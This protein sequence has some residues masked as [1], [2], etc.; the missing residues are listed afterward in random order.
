MYA[1]AYQSF[2][3]N[4]IISRRFKEFGLVPLAGDLVLDNASVEIVDSELIDNINDESNFESEEKEEDDEG[5]KDS[6]DQ[7]KGWFFVI[8]NLFYN[9]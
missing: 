5:D 3:W 7:R 9:V 6:S 1:H 4:K 2:I 8:V